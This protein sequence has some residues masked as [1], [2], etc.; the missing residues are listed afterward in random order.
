MLWCCPTTA[1]HPLYRNK[2]NS[3]SLSFGMPS[4]FRETG[5]CLAPVVYLSVTFWWPL[6]SGKARYIIEVQGCQNWHETLIDDA[7]C[8]CVCQIVMLRLVKQ[9]K[10]IK[11]ISFLKEKWLLEH[12]DFWLECFTFW[13]FCVKNCDIATPNLSFWLMWVRALSCLPISHF[14]FYNWQWIQAENNKIMTLWQKNCLQLS[15]TT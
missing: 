13:C 9:V 14:P 4:H 7:F 11:W 2:M 1:D 3:V 5:Y 10:I 12:V 6:T 15:L 8:W